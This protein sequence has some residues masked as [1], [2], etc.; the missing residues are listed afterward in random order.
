VSRPGAVLARVAA[1]ALYRTSGLLVINLAVLSGLGFAFW[2]IAA[3]LFPAADVGVF[4]GWIAASTL[5]ATVGGLGLG[6]T[7]IRQ[8]AHHREPRRLIVTCLALIGS[9]GALLCLIALLVTP[10]VVPDAL[11]LRTDGGARVVVLL[12]IVVSALSGLVDACLVAAQSGRALIVKN[13][14]GGFARCGLLP[15]MTDAGV[16]GLLVAYTVGTVLAALLAWRDVLAAYPPTAAW[17]RPGLALARPFVRFSVAN[18]LGGVI[19]ILPGTLVPLIVLAVDGPTAAAHLGI[20]FLLVGFLNFLPSSIAQAFFAQAS[21]PGV[22]A[23]HELRKATRTSY[24]VM[25]PAVAV[26]ALA[27]PLLL[28]AFGNGYAAAATTPLRILALAGLATALTYLVDAALNVHHRPLAYGAMNIVNAVLVVGGTAVAVDSGL[29]SVA[30]AWLAAQA[31]SAVIGLAVIRVP[32]RTTPEFQ[33][34][35]PLRHG[36]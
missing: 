20:A 33:G 5:L 8:L 9:A 15:L 35:R 7:L 24:V 13:L 30:W 10:I 22:D 18:Y 29:T 23:A 25:I 12:L 27:A 34:Q 26:F 1:D 28:R 36:Q 19:G 4:N 16:T 11:N 32:R 6:N 17:Q 2:T 31:A 21:R 3:R 14:A